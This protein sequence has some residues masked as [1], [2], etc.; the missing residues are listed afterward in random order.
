MPTYFL[1]YTMRHLLFLVIA[2]IGI[3]PSYARDIYN[4]NQEWRFFYASERSADEARV[5]N[6]P[7]TW[8]S[9][10]SCANY[11]KSIYAPNEWRTQRI[12]V[13][14]YGVQRVAD[15]FVNG[16][17]VGEHRGGATAFTFEITQ[18]LKYGDN[19]NILVAVNSAAQNDVLP[20]SME[21]DVESGIY[22]GVEL[23][24]TPRSA[25]SP[26]YYGSDGFFVSTTETSESAAKGDVKVYVSQLTP[27]DCEL[28]L[29]VSDQKGVA[30]FSN[31]VAYKYAQGDYVS[32]PFELKRAKL[33]SPTSPELYNFTVELHSGESVDRVEVVSGFRTIEATTSGSIKINDTPIP[34]KGVTLYHDHPAVGTALTPKE[35]ESDMALIREM[36][37]TAIHSAI[38][39][40]DQYLYDL[41]D[42]QGVVAW[43]EMPFYRSSFWGDISYFPSS[44]FREN[45]RE[46]L[47]EIIA[48]NYNHPSVIMWGLFS[49]LAPRGDDFVP[50][51]TELNE[52]ALKMDHTRPTVAMSDQNGD[53][54]QVPDIIVWRQNIG[55][56]RGSLGDIRAWSS[57]IHNSWSHMASAVSYGEQG[58]IM[59]QEGLSPLQQRRSNGEGWFAEA[60]AREFHE[61]YAKVLDSDSLFWGVWINNMFDFKSQRNIS[62]ENTSGV[63]S[64]DRG[65]R[66]DIF[67]L[68][69]SLWNKQERTLHIVNRRDNIL[70]SPYVTIRAYASDRNQPLTVEVA[71]QSYDM[72]EVAPSQFIADSV[73]VCERCDVVVRQGKLSDSVEF[74]YGSPLRAR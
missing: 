25:I 43:V 65:V 3:F 5:V 56:D 17:H 26:L 49:T 51:L 47:R 45:G 55:W 13:K 22:R 62:G 46:Q 44:R 73:F 1:L 23:I 50:Y 24:V 32:I 19:N 59:H 74:I 53:H 11:V 36:G 27:S 4:L 71:G 42:R 16:R 35:Y 10:E 2:L 60:R 7:Y 40:H 37:A 31:T 67:Y 29:T 48:Q 70:S 30:I 63:M 68:Y 52:I 15:V 54:N 12:F 34:V 39:P 72:R 33:W 57:L 9:H 58:N 61:E 41:C 38:Y 66:K 64:F 6:I 69:K 20:T 14:F 21:H 28:K 8:S 18:H